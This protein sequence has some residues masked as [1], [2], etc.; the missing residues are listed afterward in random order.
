MGERLFA[1][2]ESQL[3]E[4]LIGEMTLY[5]LESDGVDNWS[6]YGESRTETKAEFYPGDWNELDEDDQFDTDFAHIAQMRIDAGEYRELM[7]FEEV[8][9]NVQ[10]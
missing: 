5:M 4:L 10:E 8:T 9:E 1:L 3:R 7:T 6:W 2:T